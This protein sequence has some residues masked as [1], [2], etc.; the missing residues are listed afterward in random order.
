MKK[1]VI[2]LSAL[3][4]L[5]GCS[6]A[7]I[8][9]REEETIHVYTRDASS[10][11]REAFEKAI[12]LVDL[13]DTAIEVTSNGDM[14]TKVGSDEEGIGYVSL[15]TD[16]DA[17]N[18]K[19]LSFEGIEPS[20][21]TILDGS[22]AMQ[23]PFSYVSRSSGDFTS[24]E[25]ELLILA[26]IDFLCNSTEGK[27]AIQSAGVV[28][29][30]SEGE[31]WM[32]LSENHPIVNQDNSSITIKTAGSTSV[33]KSLQAALEMFQPMAGNFDFVMNQTGS[34]DGYK[35]V[36]GSEKDGANAA[37]IGFTSRDFKADEDVEVAMVQGVYCVDAVVAVVHKENPLS[38]LTKEQLRSIYSGDIIVFE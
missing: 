17:Y 33:S 38:N 19:A 10:G 20:L 27:L 36:L 11:T 24:N 3:L 21:E 1:I 18:L 32:S 14:A 22:Y 37:D 7:E 26:F 2:I 15:S 4:V 5:G 30:L 29:D 23:R 28:V 12:G 16:F 25:K 34:S 6:S 31:S 13:A 8:G 35:R 9:Q